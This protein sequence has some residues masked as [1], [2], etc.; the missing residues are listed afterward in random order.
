MTARQPDFDSLYFRSA[1]GR[2]PTGVTVVT[3]ESPDERMPIGLTISSFNSVSL[4]PPM[5]LWMLSRKA[6]SLA[7][8]RN[9]Q[10]YVIHVLSAAQLHLARKFAYGSQAQRFEGVALR[11]TSQGTLMLDDDDVA[12]WFECHNV[13]R[14]QAGDH[15][16]LIGQVERCHRRF[17]PPLVYH[18]GD[19]DLTPLPATL[20][21]S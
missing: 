8:F 12:A 18:A 2:F 19:F 11:R 13:Q 20:A 5:V 3:A 10:R 9:V 1:L 16:I 21:D 17:I 14:H 6:A 4:E 7:H 15:Y